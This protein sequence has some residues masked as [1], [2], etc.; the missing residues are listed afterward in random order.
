MMM[1][2]QE[3]VR[4]SDEEAEYISNLMSGDDSF[5]GL[6]RDHPGIRVDRRTIILDRADAEILRDHFTVRLARVG[7]DADY[8]PNKEG[9]I[10]EQ[11]IDTFFL[12]TKR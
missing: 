1:S 11:L 2:N 10:L 7:F 5:A 8:T 3:T 12:P 9:A 4:L 6:L